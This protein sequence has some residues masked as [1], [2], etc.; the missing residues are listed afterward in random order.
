ME[1]ALI[2]SASSFR[3]YTLKFSPTWLPKHDLSKDGLNRQPNVEAFEAKSRQR[4]TG[5]EEMQRDG[6]IVFLSE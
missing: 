4:T 1:F 6:E 2:V 5:N 3:C